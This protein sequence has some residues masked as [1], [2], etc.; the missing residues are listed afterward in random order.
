MGESNISRAVHGDAVEDLDERITRLDARLRHAED[1]VTL[2]SRIEGLEYAAVELDD[3][4]ENLSKGLGLAFLLISAVC[5]A[6]ILGKSE[7]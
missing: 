4:I 3:R 7:A 6:I 5:W 2:E 1:A